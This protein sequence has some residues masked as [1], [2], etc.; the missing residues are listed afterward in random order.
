MGRHVVMTIQVTSA[1]LDVN[2]KHENKL[3]GVLL[4]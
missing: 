4:C 3:L 1:T 2:V